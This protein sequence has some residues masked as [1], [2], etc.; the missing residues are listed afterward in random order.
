MNAQKILQ[1]VVWKDI[2]GN[3]KLIEQLKLLI[4]LLV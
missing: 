3:Q 2:E 4:K 1:F